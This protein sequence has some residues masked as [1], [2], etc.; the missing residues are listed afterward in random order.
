MVHACQAII[1]DSPVY[2]SPSLIL[3]LSPPPTTLPLEPATIFIQ[4]SN[5]IERPHGGCFRQETNSR[6]APK[7]SINYYICDRVA[8]RR[9]QPWA[10][11]AD[12]VVGKHQVSHQFP[13]KTKIYEKNICSF[14][15]PLSFGV[16]CST[17]RVNGSIWR[18]ET[19]IGQSETNEPDQGTTQNKLAGKTSYEAER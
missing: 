12:T 16:I 2:I 8:F 6:L 13:H 7:S 11:P 17:P 19:K 14:F 15:K 1:R 5:H 18:L 3:C 9:F 10:S 4:S